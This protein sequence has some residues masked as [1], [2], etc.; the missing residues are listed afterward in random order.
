LDSAS[1]SRLLRIVTS[2][3]KLIERIG[4]DAEHESTAAKA[5]ILWLKYGSCRSFSPVV[6][7][8]TFHR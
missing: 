3:D 2:L 5:W 1:I 8:I 6:K 7:V 4:D